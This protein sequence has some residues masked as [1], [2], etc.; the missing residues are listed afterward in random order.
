MIQGCRRETLSF[1]LGQ[2]AEATGNRPAHSGT[3]KARGHSGK[4]GGGSGHDSMGIL[5]D[6]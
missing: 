6:K 5:L 3:V 1:A 2:R 4:Q